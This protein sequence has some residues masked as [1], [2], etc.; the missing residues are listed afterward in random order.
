V[1][2]DGYIFG[3]IHDVIVKREFRNQNIGYTLIDG[4]LKH[5]LIRVLSRVQTVCREKHA[6]FYKK[7]G[8]K[9]SFGRSVSLRKFVNSENMLGS[10]E[11]EEN[12]F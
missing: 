4:V 9:E 8:F 3:Y 1:L 5:P 7:F 12:T 10:T 6:N 2:T 11:K